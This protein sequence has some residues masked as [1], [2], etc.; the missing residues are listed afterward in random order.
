MTASAR[1][2]PALQCDLRFPPAAI[3]VAPGQEQ[4]L[5]VLAMT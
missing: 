2:R 3:P 5:P 4:V 1:P